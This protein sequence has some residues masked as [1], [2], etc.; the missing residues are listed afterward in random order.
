MKVL[1]R[2]LCFFS[3]MLWILHWVLGSDYF[4][5]VV[6]GKDVAETYFEFPIILITFVIIAIQFGNAGLVTTAYSER[7]YLS[8]RN[9]IA[10]NSAKASFLADMSHK[11]RTPM[12]GGVA[13]M[14]LLSSIS[15]G[16]EKKQIFKKMQG[17]FY[18]MLRIIGDILDITKIE[19]GELGLRP[20]GVNLLSWFAS[21][22]S[23]IVPFAD[24]QGVHL[25]VQSD[26]ILPG[27]V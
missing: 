11:I 26:P 5:T 6:V 3:L 12:T 22:I 14:D 20:V 10:A 8:N 17:S 16:I 27:L 23:S 24:N 18:S 25:R 1:V 9:E 7:I 13:M 4:G 19:A 21:T 2:F 15:L